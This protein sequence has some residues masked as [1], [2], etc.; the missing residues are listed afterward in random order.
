[1]VVVKEAFSA[2]KVIELQSFVDDRG[3]FRETFSE[4]NHRAI[5]ITETFLQDNQSRSERG[6]LRGLHFTVNNPQAQLMTVL[7]G[8]VFDVVVDIRQGS[9]TYGQYFGIT[10]SDS[11]PQQIYMPDGF[12]HG[13]LVLS[14][15]ADLHYKVSKLYRAEDEAGLLWNDP[16]L[17]I[18]WPEFPTSI[19]KRDLSHPTL[20]H[21]DQRHS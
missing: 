9:S 7:R 20:Q 6:V 12:A 17:N 1:M 19:S 16:E 14:D 18:E 5:G 4:S 3:F 8:S 2:I 13:F 21:Y 11:G 15:Y 10:L